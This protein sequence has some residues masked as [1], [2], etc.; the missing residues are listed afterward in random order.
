MVEMLCA[1]DKGRLQEAEQAAREALAARIAFWDG[2]H[3]ALSG[4]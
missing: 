3:A 2:V 4:R 1:G